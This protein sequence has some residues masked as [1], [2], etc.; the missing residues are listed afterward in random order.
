[1]SDQTSDETAVVSLPPPASP[2]G[3]DA[4][5]LKPELLNAYRLMLQYQFIGAVGLTVILAAI[6]LAAFAATSSWTP[7][8]LIL[9]AMT[10]MLGAY[11][12]ALTRL[13]DV[14][15]FSVALI[16]P[17]TSQLGGRYLAMYSLVPAIIGAIAAV[18]LYVVFLAG[19]VGGG[20]GI[21]PVM[22]C[23]AGQK[24]ASLSDVL[25]YFGPKEAQDYG[26]VFV[27]AFAAGFS[28]RLV[29]NML[30]SLV[31]QLQHDG[32]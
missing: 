26:K 24:C 9:V 20:G 3:A 17:I 14:D 31:S 25:R 27:W 2:P 8:L 1:M 5:L 13:Y 16:T 19:M 32:K 10:G 21:V 18:L 23:A 7:P 6:L 30:Q 28:E 11:F 15:Q 4:R 22:D 12:S 29:P